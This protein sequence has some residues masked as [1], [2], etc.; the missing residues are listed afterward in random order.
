MNSDKSERFSLVRDEPPEPVKHYALLDDLAR[1][2]RRSRRSRATMTVALVVIGLLAGWIGGISLT[3]AF[4]RPKT[5]TDFPPNTPTAETAA[6]S[7]KLQPDTRPSAVIIAPAGKSARSRDA[8]ADPEP[9]VE[10]QPPRATLTDEEK[11]Q[12]DR[13]ADVPTGEQSA[14]EIGQNAIDKILKENDKIR[15]GK[16]LKANKNEE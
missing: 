1:Q 15:R 13:K 7:S 16:H 12:A 9:P 6:P 14:K 2:P 4:Q 10:L 5:A 11:G 3:G 8:Q